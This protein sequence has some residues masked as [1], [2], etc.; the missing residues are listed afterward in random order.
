MSNL[1]LFFTN[2]TRQAS[3]ILTEQ[4][5]NIDSRLKELETLRDMALSARGL[6]LNGSLDEIGRLLHRSWQTKKTLASKISTPDIDRMYDAAIAA[7]ALG[8]K[9]AGAGAGGFLLVY[10]PRERQ[11]AVRE[12]LSAYR[13]LPFMLSRDGSKVILN[14]RGYEWR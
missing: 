12:A 5:R 2:T 8:G 4:R 1:L 13:E 11:N 10:C 3:E 9:V 7:G 14:T 6:L